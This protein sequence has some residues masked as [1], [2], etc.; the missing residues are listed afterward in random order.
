MS[1]KKVYNLHQAGRIFA[2]KDCIFN[3]DAIDLPKA[4]IFKQILQTVG[5]SVCGQNKR[6]G[7]MRQG[8]SQ[9]IAGSE[10]QTALIL[11]PIGFAAGVSR[12]AAGVYGIGHC[13]VSESLKKRWT[14]QLV[15]PVIKRAIFASEL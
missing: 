3:Y 9:T 11:P 8:F 6:I 4:D 5:L 10:I 7:I 1:G 13:A 15:P 12:M 14:F 2:K